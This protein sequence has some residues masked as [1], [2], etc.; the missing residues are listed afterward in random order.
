MCMLYEHVASI[1]TDITVLI[2]DTLT[3]TAVIDVS[4]RSCCV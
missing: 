3:I 2:H 4:I 1:C